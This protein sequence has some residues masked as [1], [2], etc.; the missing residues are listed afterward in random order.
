MSVQARNAQKKLQ[1]PDFVHVQEGVHSTDLQG[2]WPDATYKVKVGHSI[3]TELIHALMFVL[4]F[5]VVAFTRE[6]QSESSTITIQT[7]GLGKKIQNTWVISTS[8]FHRIT[9]GTK[10]QHF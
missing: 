8:F 3:I 5:Q 10:S 7:S 1:A 4:L 9:E 6:D 2:L